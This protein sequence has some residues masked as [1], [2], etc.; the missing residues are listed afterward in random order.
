[1]EQA[2]DSEREG[3]AIC[4]QILHE[5]ADIPGIAGANL[6]NLGDPALVVAAIEESGLRRE[7]EG[8]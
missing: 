3:V 7:Q 6:V 4:A 8:M 2:P 1:L 5:V